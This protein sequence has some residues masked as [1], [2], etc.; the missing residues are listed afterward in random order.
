MSSRRAL[1]VGVV[2]LLT[3]QFLF[4]V[5]AAGVWWAFRTGLFE[6]DPPAVVAEN[7]RTAVAISITLALNLVAAIAFL[8]RRRGFGWWVLATVQ[9]IDIG[10]TTVIGLNFAA[11]SDL[12]TAEE[13]WAATAVAALTLILVLTLRPKRSPV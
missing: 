1:L 4:W 12:M 2:L 5:Y 10:V 6:P 13:W 8:V 7:T 11:K 9:V 3:L